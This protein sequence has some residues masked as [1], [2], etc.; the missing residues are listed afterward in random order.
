[1]K[2]SEFENV[3]HFVAS[4]Q[5]PGLECSRMWVTRKSE[6][7]LILA[8][9]LMRFWYATLQKLPSCFG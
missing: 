9:S 4:I 2:P 7:N 1:M 8:G 3:A 6:N 5:I